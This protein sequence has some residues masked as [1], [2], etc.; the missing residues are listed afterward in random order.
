[1]FAKPSNLESEDSLC[2]ACWRFNH[3][4]LCTSD[5]KS[6]SVFPSFLNTVL[7]PEE[8]IFSEIHCLEV[9]LQCPLCTA[10]NFSLTIIIYFLK[11]VHYAWLTHPIC[12]V[13]SLQFVVF[14]LV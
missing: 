14:L 7:M 3:V 4:E 11:T 5:S 9:M 6:Y 2:T 1:M 10:H 8:D 12:N 13:T